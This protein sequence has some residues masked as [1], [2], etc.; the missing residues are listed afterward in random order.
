MDRAPECRL[1]RATESPRGFARFLLAFLLLPLT[2]ATL[3]AEAL[4]AQSGTIQGRVTSAS[5]GAPLENAFIRVAT[6]EGLSVVTR[7]TNRDGFWSA[8]VGAGTYTVIAQTIG[9]AEVRSAPANV[10]AGQVARVDLAMEMRPIVLGGVDVMTSIPGVEDP[11]RATEAVSS[12]SREQ[13]SVRPAVTPVDHLRSL[14]Q[15]DVIQQGVQSTNVVVRGFNNIFSG[16]LHTLTDH[17]MSGVPSLRVNVMSFLPTTD[18]DLERMELVFGPA[19]AIYGPNT[20]NGVLHMLTRSPL[21]DQGTSAMVMGGE[22]SLFGG[23]VRTAH[24]LT[25][26]LGLKVS[27]QYLRAD[28]WGFTDATEVAEQARFA[29]NREL[30]RA[31]MMRAVGIDAAEADRRI[32]RIGAR[33]NDIE[34]WSVDA[35]A[36]WAISD[37]ATA[38]FSVGRSNAASQI[39]LTGLGAGQV[40][41]WSYTYYQT[42]FEQGR[43]FG[44]F[45]LNQSNAGSTFLLRNGAPIVDR[46]RLYVAQL[47]HGRELGTRNTLLYGLDF[48]YTDPETEGTI[49]GIYEDEDQTREI[50]GYLQNRFNVTPELDLVMAGRV[51][52]HTGLPDPVF[53]PRLGLVYNPAEGQTFRAAFNRAFSTPSSLNQFLDLGTAIPNAQLAQLGYSVRV[54]GTGTEG[55]RFR[56]GGAYQMRSPFTP[57]Q[58]GGPA[59]LLPAEA[60][61]F[62][63]AAAQVVGQSAGLP[64]P[65]VAYIQGLQPTPADIPSAYLDINRPQQPGQPLPRL[66][67]LDL[68]DVDPI[69]ESLQSTF[70]VGYRGVL[71]DRAALQADV[72]YSRRSQLVTPLTVRT[73]LITMS[74]PELGAY[75]VPRLVP[76]LMAGGMSAAEAEATATAIATGMAGVPVGVISSADIAANG[77]QLLSTYTNVDDDFNVWGVDLSG[78]VFLDDYISLRGSVGFVNDDH[79]ETSRGE[80]V[81]LNAPKRKASF[82]VAYRNRDMGFSS[83][84]RARYAEGFPAS[85]GVYEGLEC[86]GDRAPAITLPCVSSSRL[87]DLNLSYRLPGMSGATAQLAVTNLLDREFQSFPGTPDVGR[88]AILR[89]RYEF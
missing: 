3:G 32:D 19:A 71:S 79:F 26:N 53:S 58:A 51:D 24:L 7:S 12:I 42:R 75:L 67:E 89:L 66:S 31:D 49:N 61:A 60:V 50:G 83:E 18:D 1:N 38:Y 62:W 40:E 84:V 73:P 23:S 87:L 64:A 27:A 20:A 2:L 86:L 76:V 45:Y 17:R 78:E 30:W 39:E 88:M 13:L 54:Q 25:E 68:Q 48:V 80:I 65:V 41:D 21:R 55:F 43:F 5:T 14:A 72:W 81:T 9:Y 69:R 74:G 35:R 10:Q 85:S 63:A 70:E 8:S 34:R 82:A 46:S 11:R 52:F 28:E 57:A 6:P 44:Q 16:A 29:A 47:R 77:A 15:V 36:D 33:N 56:Q 37:D 22:R 59:Q 4:E